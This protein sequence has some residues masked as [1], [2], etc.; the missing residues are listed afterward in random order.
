MH[1]VRLRTDGPLSR[2]AGGGGGVERGRREWITRPARQTQ[3]GDGIRGEEVRRSSQLPAAFDE[4]LVW[5][6]DGFP[7]VADSL[8]EG[9]DVVR[10]RAARAHLLSR[11]HRHAPLQGCSR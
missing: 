10:L 4:H 6:G 8:E 11:L 5:P 3:D 9:G 2:H 7:A 1:G